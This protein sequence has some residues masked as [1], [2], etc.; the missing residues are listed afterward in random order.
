MRSKSALDI[1]GPWS[2]IKLEIVRD[3]AKAYSTA[4]R[5]R[6]R[7]VYIDA[8]A[9]SGLHIDRDT[10]DF[11]PGSP[12]NALLVRPPF[13]EFYFVDLDGDKVE[14]LRERVGDRSDVHI[15]QGDCNQILLK[16]VLPNVRYERYERGL[17]LLDPYGLHLRWEL[18]L[19]IAQ[20]G[21]I[22][23]FLNFPIMDINQNVLRK[24]PDRIRPAQARRMTGFWGDESW[25]DTCYTSEGNLFGF[26]RKRT[27][28]E[29]VAVFCERLRT[30][31][32]FR[33]VPEPLPIRNTRGAVVYYLVFAAHH[34]LAQG[35]VADIFARHAGKGGRR[36]RKQPD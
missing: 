1:I 24:N 23:T 9:G 33:H 35:I 27:N 28:E 2:Q 17:C 11:V 19:A 31:A 36:G 25:R 20:T 7:H 13:R 6:F 10:G 30:V 26:Q 12:T 15:L 34:R 8:F 21:A 29:V 32:G 16:E 5:R 18:T 14:W 22:D 3:Y 4:L